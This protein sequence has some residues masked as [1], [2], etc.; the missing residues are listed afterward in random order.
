[1]SSGVFYKNAD[2]AIEWLCK[3]FGFEVRLKVDGNG[4]VQHSELVFGEAVIMV[5]DE[6]AQQEKLRDKLVSPASIDGKNTQSIMFYVDDVVALCERA[7]A[8]GGTV[9]YEPT[10]SDYGEEYWADKSCQ[11]RDLEG[12]HWWFA[13][14]VRG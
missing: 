1:M 7:R 11:I 12:H 3:A 2:A 5:G 6:R 9:T 14:R 4:L 8:A 13:Q 10:V